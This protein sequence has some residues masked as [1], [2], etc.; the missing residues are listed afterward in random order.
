MKIGILTFHRAC[1]YGAVLQC[2]ALQEVFKGMGHEVRVIDYRQPSIERDYK[3]FKFLSFAKN[4][5]LFRLHRYIRIRVIRKWKFKRFR[6]E[7]LDVCDTCMNAQE[8]PE[9]Y[10]AYVIG[11]DQVFSTTITDGIDPV[12]SLAFKF[13]SQALRIGYAISMNRESIGEI[14][15]RWVD[16]YHR[17]TSF[18][19][20]ERAFAETIGS[21]VQADIPVCLDPTLWA[22]ECLWQKMASQWVEKKRYMVL[23]EVR[24]QKGRRK[25]VYNQAKQLAKKEGCKLIDLAAHAYRVEEWV[26]L[27]AHAERVI[28]DS[29]HGAVFS[30]LFQRPLDVFVLH[31]G[32]DERIINL[33]HEL[34]AESCVRE[35]SDSLSPYAPTLD[36]SLIRSNLKK[37]RA[38][39]AL[40]FAHA[41]SNKEVIND[42]M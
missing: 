28:T 4:C 16:I 33:L 25:F 11:S 12:Y 22:E 20:R 21:I 9:N 15:Q 40:F 6:R 37:L 41:V 14:G 5:L 8:V 18:S 27:I 34:G 30:L 38:Q 2:Y 39:S 3:C 7:Y 19:L 1:N 10:D 13:P 29:F 23:Y 36:R 17:F 32:L 35:L 31:D 26:S 42:K 24:C